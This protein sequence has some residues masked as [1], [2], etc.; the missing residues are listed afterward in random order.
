MF[1]TRCEANF[2][3]A[4]AVSGREGILVFGSSSGEEID[5]GQHVILGA[6]DQFLDLV[7]ELGTLDQIDLERALDVPV[8][9]AGRI[10][11]LRASR[12]FGNV[13]A[14]I[15]YRHLSLSDRLSIAR[16]MAGLKLSAPKDHETDHAKSI[17]FAEWLSARGQSDDAIMRFWSLFILPVFNCKIE[18]VAAHDA[19]GFTRTYLIGRAT[20]AAIGYPKRGLSTLIGTPAERLLRSRGAELVMNVRAESLMVLADSSFDIGL[21]NGASLQSKAVLACL[22]PNVLSAIL[23][24]DDRRFAASRETLMAIEYSPIVAVHL[25]YERPV[26]TERVTAFVDLGL[27]WVF[28][29]TSLRRTSTDERQHI[30]VSLSGADEWAKMTKSEVLSQIQSRMK[31]AFPKVGE[32]RLVNSSIAKTLEATI[33]IKP[34]SHAQRLDAEISIPGLYF[35]GDWTNTGLPATM[36]GAVQSGNVA[37]ELAIAKVHRSAK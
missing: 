18:E 35:A 23:P 36:E 31:I 11:R 26:M 17:S 13:A 34:N 3:R 28:N 8:S 9:N 12:I 15:R 7:D 1:E 30:V 37:A 32:T 29:D 19:I 22:A 5:N 20:D 21:S 4:A 16:V 2:G 10:F 27:Q 6:C 14:L 25:W 33:K 24:E